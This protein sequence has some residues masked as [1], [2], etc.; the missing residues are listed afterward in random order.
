M[1][2]VQSLLIAFLMLP[3]F[4]TVT[5][6][7]TNEINLTPAEKAFIEKHPEIHLGVDPKFIPYEFFDS[8]GEYKG[9]AADYIKLL[10]D[11]TG[12]KMTVAKDLSWSE[13]Y[14]KAVEKQLDVL[15]CI[16]KTREREN[17]FIYSQPY[18]PF[19]R[20]IYINESNN[21]I[22]SFHDLWNTKVAVQAN[23]SHHSYLKTFPSIQL[24]LYPSVK[25]ALQ[26]V[27]IG[28]ETAFI[29]NYATS[30][31]LIK[32]N[33]ITGLKYIKLK[34]EQEEYLYF[35]VR[36]DWPELVSIINKGL[37]SITEEEKIAINNR[38][39]GVE[40][41]FDYRNVIKVA[42]ILGLLIL[43]SFYWIVRLRKEVSKRKIIQE[44]LKS[45]RDEAESAN[46]IKSIFLARMS[47][48]IRTPLNAI[49]GMAY[50]MKKTNINSTQYNYLDRITDASNNMLGI[51][52]DILD[53]SKIE[54][55]KIE[56]EKTPF[57]LDK[58]LGQIINIL[59]FKIE[60][61]GIDFSIENDPDLPSSFLG[62]P[63]RIGQVLINIV[64]NAIKFTPQGMVSV[65]VHRLK[66]EQDLYTLEF[67]VKD[68]GIGMSE[69]QIDQ[70]FKPFDQGDSSISRR[71]GGTGLGLSI[72]K[73]LLEMMGGEIQVESVLGEGSTFRVQLTLEAEPDQKHEISN[74][75]R[76]VYF[77]NLRVLVIEKSD[78]NTKLLKYY[79]HSFGI[80]AEFA[81]TETE[82]M[83]LIKQ[84]LAKGARP[85]NLL[86]IDY[87]TPKDGGIAFYGDLKHLTAMTEMP[88]CIL[89]IPLAR[90]D[91]F[92]AL[93]AER[94]DFG[95]HKP[96]LPSVLFNA[97]IEIFN[98]EM[99]KIH[100]QTL[101]AA[102][103]ETSTVNYPY[104]VLIVEDNKTN[105]F[106]AQS[107]LEQ[108]GFKASITENGQEGYDF[109]T[110]HQDDLD[111]IL[112]DLHMPVL[113]GFEATALIRAKDTN[114][115]II[116]MTADAIA[117]IEEKCSIIGINHYIS[118]PFNPDI[119]VAT[120][121]EVM[122]SQKGRV[123]SNSLDVADGIK[124]LGGKSDLYY[125]VLEE[126]YKENLEVPLILQ[127][128]IKLANYK[129]AAQ[130][131][132]KIKSSSGNIGAQQLYKAASVL[133]NSLSDKN[134]EKITTLHQDFQKQLQQVL[135]EIEQILL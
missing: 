66:K 39:I 135:L 6:A 54:A 86:I 95:I 121:L 8:D 33:G 105:Q 75:I 23:T 97:I 60:E 122:E 2:L 80:A 42:V 109:F 79:L 61:Q 78:L 118:K 59:S 103:P 99:L 37:A 57:N 67:V 96:I 44:E 47:H 119:F 126:Y 74:A 90:E 98:I 133:Q 120:I 71:F 9:I 27:A 82:S 4:T 13:A 89:M 63:T 108:S 83:Q 81:S 123:R 24:S 52:N 22:K 101:Q 113:N 94:I 19:Q 124:R 48:E 3:I 55:G 17:Y 102:T 20:V 49:I 114:I 51:I 53:F 73:N 112:M 116:A 11:R 87:E 69:E 127:E 58:L 131:V 7:A 77:H 1:K 31:Y 50:L 35:A 15:P 26:A 46:H 56:I 43:I 16:S 107:I 76:S 65:T 110:A 10:S 70:I 132:H 117:G 92:S 40:Q 32:S 5:F 12:L 64:N 125:L 25:E 100:G 34:A 111:V 84:A 62:D 115:P 134:P 91:L 72:S 129:E 30:N 45:A 28:K 21:Y 68:S 85:Y 104:H 88:K 41:K 29:G 106:I 18:Y 130:I 36:D 38:W 14:Q 93:A 128:T